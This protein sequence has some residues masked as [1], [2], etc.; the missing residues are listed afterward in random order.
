MLPLNFWP[1]MKREKTGV[2]SLSFVDTLLIAIAVFVS[3]V[4]MA[5][6]AA[7]IGYVYRHQ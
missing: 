7:L 5:M 4:V 1:E 3:I 2:L 6:V